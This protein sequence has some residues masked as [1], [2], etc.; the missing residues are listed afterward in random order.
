MVELAPK[1]I[2]HFR[3]ML[4]KGTSPALARVYGVFE[5]KLEGQPR[6]NLMLMANQTK[7]TYMDSSIDYKFDLKGSLLNRKVLPKASQLDK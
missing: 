3:N 6:I 7:K 5:F 2:E 1:M 4:S